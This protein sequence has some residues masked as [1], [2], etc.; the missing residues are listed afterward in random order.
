MLPEKNVHAS[1]PPALLTKMHEAAQEQGVTPD[2]FESKAI[3][4]TLETR[5]FEAVLTYGK[6]R[7]KERGLKPEDVATEI[8]KYRQEKQSPHGR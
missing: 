6:R 7:A 4:H 8:A 3:E 1:V 2:E 5:K